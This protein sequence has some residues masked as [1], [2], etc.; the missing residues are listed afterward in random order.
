MSDTTEGPPSVIQSVDL[1]LIARTI[2]SFTTDTT[3]VISAVVM[4]ETPDDPPGYG[5]SEQGIVELL[6]EVMP[7][8][9]TKATLAYLGQR[10][11]LVRRGLKGR[12]VYYR[13][14]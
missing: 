13:K 14:A 4:A 9:V 7:P 8:A 11:Y 2:G 6:L 5:A 10:G 1:R 12:G 3:R